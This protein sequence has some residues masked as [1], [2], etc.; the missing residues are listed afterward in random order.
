MHILVDY[1]SPMDGILSIEESVLLIRT[2]IDYAKKNQKIAFIIKPHPS[3]DL[4]I[5]S[6]LIKDKTENIYLINKKLPPDDALYISDVL[7]TK[8]STLG[9]EAMI[10][11]VQVVSVLLDNEERFKLYGEAA[12]YVYD[13]LTL[14]SVIRNNLSSVEDMNKWKNSFDSKR[15]NFISA[16]YPKLDKS[17]SE[18]LVKAVSNHL[19]LASLNQNK[20]AFIKSIN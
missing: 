3:A 17:S 7:F 2:L 19:K 8:F 5:L 1:N 14:I 18:I 12:E 16:Y 6:E 13:Q 11:D 10:Y 20:E 9:I 15:K 4:I